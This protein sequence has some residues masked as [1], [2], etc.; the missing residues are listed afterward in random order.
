MAKE[1]AVICTNVFK[2]QNEQSIRTTFNEM[3]LK[4]I[5]YLENCKINS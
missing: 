5:N 1:D 3:W 2:S 4:L